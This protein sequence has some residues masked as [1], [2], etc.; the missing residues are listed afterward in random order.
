MNN[1]DGAGV[2]RR[3]RLAVKHLDNAEGLHYKPQQ[4]ELTG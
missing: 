1:F 2:S 4:I 3:A